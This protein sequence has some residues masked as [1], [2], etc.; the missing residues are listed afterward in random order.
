VVVDPLVGAFV[1]MAE[2]VAVELAVGLGARR[3]RR[4]RAGELS[5]SQVER[6]VRESV[7]QVAEALPHD[8]ADLPE[9]EWR[10][11]LAAAR[12][13]LAAVSPLAVT[14]ALALDMR[15][16]RLVAH[17]RERAGDAER[18]AR[19][20][21]AGEAAYEMILAVAC[22]QVVQAVVRL[23]GFSDQ[24]QVATLQ[25]VGEVRDAVEQLASRPGAEMTARR[26]ERRYLD[27]VTRTLGRLELFGVSRG[28]VPRTLPMADAYVRAAVAR[29]GG[30]RLDDDELT[31]AG[32][33]V[34]SAL[35]DHRRVLLRGGAGAGKTTLLRW[36]AVSA[37]TPGSG[38]DATP[39]QVPFLV[40]LRHHA[41]QP[42]PSP[43]RLVDAVAEVLTGEMPTGWVSDRLAAGAALVLVDGVDELEPARR[44]EAKAWL[45]Q[46]A[47][48]Y[49]AARIVV[50]TRPFA[51]GDDWLAP[52][53]FV[54]FD[55]LPFSERGIGDYVAAWHEAARADLPD[56]AAEHDWLDAC[57]DGLRG[58]LAA[59]PDLRRLA[60]SPLLCG[61]LCALYRD[62]DMHLPRHRKGLYDAALD[63]LLVRW[64][65]ARGVRVDEL[66]S[67]SKEEQV[68]L[69]QR[70]AYSMVKNHELTLHRSDAVDRFAHHMRGL[71]SQQVEPG[72]VLQRTLERTGLL[73]EPV[74]DEVQ[75]VHRTFRDHLAAKEVVDAGELGF[76]VEQA[77][78][79]H[80][81]DV[82]VSAVAHARPRER[83]QVLR[84]LVE[85]NA[86]ARN[87]ARA[88]HRLH[89]VA[90]S[91]L[92]QA[93][94]LDTD[95]ARALVE[96]AAARLIPPATL[97]DADL[98]ARAGPFVLDLL[99]GPAGLTPR[100]AA[101][102]VRTAAMIGGEGVR[103][104][105]AEFIPIAEANVIDELLRAWRRAEDPDGYAR[106][107]L[108][109]VDFGDHSVEVRGWQ[110]V[111][112]LAHLR[113]LA[114]V[115]CFGDFSDL[116][117]I[118]AMPS[119]RRLELVQNELVRNL[120]PLAASRTLRALHLRSGCEFLTDLSPLAATAV[121]ELHL[122]LVAADL[123][124]LRP[125]NLRRLVVRDAR[126][127]HGLHL[128]P[129]DLELDELVVDNPPRS[130]DIRGVER[131]R[132]LRHVGIRGTPRP[133]EVAALARLPHLE[134]LTLHGP[135]PTGADL[136]PLDHIA[137]IALV[138]PGT[139]HG[140]SAL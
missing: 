60:G 134:R 90:A 127:A 87:D 67:L 78:L 58:Q 13:A 56:D 26:F 129:A 7:R 61:L 16:E 29:S 40:P 139:P 65:E 107:V 114:N 36:L 34:T 102:V 137:H 25:A 27:H 28:R 64:D 101:A 19:L 47:G 132:R 69:L 123:A 30:G 93:D 6:R 106:G 98:L 112:C 21:P 3:W 48:A 110:R 68:V 11:A 46:L 14:D 55:L 4:G 74:P 33:D 109:E 54:T 18:S 2:G 121:E 103:E 20:S 97:D 49:P 96:Q 95:E 12:D 23:P 130:R 70:F 128:L 126:L 50:T 17:V 124:T 31:G 118:A 91:C 104:R 57:E 52:A 80:W 99:P 117:P 111:R 81:H 140:A 86:A 85:G 115:T 43:E 10:A 84:R 120:L 22:H 38:D 24:A 73:R 77:H 88:R 75:F 89:L 44:D 5:S 92:D 62:G 51:V 135:D 1:A 72:P 122:H 59:R 108:A 41:R 8:I 45:A 133:D 76:L 32:I 100:Q 9:G 105:L 15:P 113:H 116:R 71:R 82:V 37:A 35:A 131:W 138:G 94:V 53:G 125:G 119:L 39:V 66:P 79:D 63:L 42:F 136:G 83:E